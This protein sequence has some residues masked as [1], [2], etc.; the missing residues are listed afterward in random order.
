M[1]PPIEKIKG[2]KKKKKVWSG[3][4]TLR[5]LWVGKSYKVG[6]SNRHVGRTERP[7]RMVPEEGVF[8][9][10]NIKKRTKLLAKRGL[11]F[12][13][14]WFYTPDCC[15][16][17]AGTFLHPIHFHTASGLPLTSLSYYKNNSIALHL[18]ARLIILIKYRQRS[19]VLHPPIYSI[20]ENAC[21]WYA[22][23]QSVAFLRLIVAFM[24]PFDI[25]MHVYLYHAIDAKHVH[26]L[27]KFERRLSI[28]VLRNKAFFTKKKALSHAF[29]KLFVSLFFSQTEW[30][31]CVQI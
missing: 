12:T 27:V 8:I 23:L 4:F 14:H 16:L 15:Q 10:Y 19:H 26:I 24:N 20:C 17:A 5:F 21:E 31:T 29:E 13:Q 7:K 9:D 30:T 22:Q 18:Q 28:S 2:L 11:V 25:Q 3:D 6:I 1:C